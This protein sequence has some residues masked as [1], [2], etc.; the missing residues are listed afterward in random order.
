M[1][2]ALAFAPAGALVR[3]RPLDVALQGFLGSRVYATV[4]GWTHDLN[5][6]LIGA[7]VD[8]TGNGL[9]LGVQ[10]ARHGLEVPTF[11]Y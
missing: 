1:T 3:Q 9:S 8:T 6:R 4:V 2:L 10:P 11:L 5:W 7:Y